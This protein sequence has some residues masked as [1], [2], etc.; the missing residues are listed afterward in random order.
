MVGWNGWQFYGVFPRIDAHLATR[1]A[2]VG[3]DD[4]LDA[5]AAAWTAHRKWRG[6]A[7]QVCDADRDEQG[8][9]VTIYY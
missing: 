3:A 2:G 7:V 8:L 4:V 9:L 6:A 5:A 1:P